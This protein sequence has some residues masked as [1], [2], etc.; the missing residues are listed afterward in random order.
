MKALNVI[1]NIVVWLIVVIAAGMMVFTIVSVSTFDRAERSL[2]GYKAFIVLSDSMSKTDFNAGDL[3]LVKEVDPSTLQEGDIISYTSQNSSNYGEVVT[4]KI[5]KLTTDA[6]G[7]PG[8]ITYGTTTDTD[9]ETIVTYEYVIGKYSK[10]IPKVGTFFQFL[11]STPGYIVCILIP[12]LI[13]ILLEGIRC[14]RLS[15]KY[16]AEQQAE[17]QQGRNKFEAARAEAQ[18]MRQEL[19]KRRA[20]RAAN[21]GDA[22]SGGEA[23]PQEEPPADSAAKV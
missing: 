18:R 5:R 6:N 15:R 17:L 9:D 2:F 8:F 3:V 7:E 19:R 10:S 21:R 4:H 16:K 20:Q 13:L 1:R 23:K 14:I 12:F 11:K 22:A